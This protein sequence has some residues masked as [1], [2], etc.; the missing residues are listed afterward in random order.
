MDTW[1]KLAAWGVVALVAFWIVL[2][3]V[4]II[5]GFLSW[6]IGMLITLGIV[7]VL[8]LGAYLLIT[9]LL[10]NSGAGTSRTRERERIFE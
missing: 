2:Q 5:L 4:G 1:L 10:G 3:I 8:L 9:K 6:L 7:A